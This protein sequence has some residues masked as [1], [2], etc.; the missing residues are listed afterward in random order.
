[1]CS[2]DLGGRTPHGHG[3]VAPSIPHDHPVVAAHEFL[4]GL[5]KTLKSWIRLLESIA[6]VYGGS[7]PPGIWL[8]KDDCP[9]G[10]NWVHMAF[11][12]SR[13]L[14]LTQEWR[15]FAHAQ[16]LSL[17]QILHFRFNGEDTLFVTVFEYLGGRMG[18]CSES[19]SSSE[20]DSSSDDDEEEDAENPPNI[21]EEPDDSFQG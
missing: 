18:C 6:I 7:P 2:S 11:D 20:E 5:H 10:P 21:K 14:V 17:D 15:T 1:M 13:R 16:K 9:N 12:N 8:Q 19:S 3:G 4:V